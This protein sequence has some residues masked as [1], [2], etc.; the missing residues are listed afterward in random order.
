MHSVILS[1]RDTK[2]PVSYSTE[3][4]RDKRKTVF[5]CR[6]ISFISASSFTVYST[7]FFGGGG[8]L[9]CLLVRPPSNWGEGGAA[10]QEEE[11]ED[12]VISRP[13]FPL[14]LLLLL[15]F[16]CPGPCAAGK[17]SAGAGKEKKG[18]YP[19]LRPRARVVFPPPRLK[20]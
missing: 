10:E 7:L 13:V 1:P 2:N 18:N 15:L 20:N 8:P 5:L 14:L 19:P 3:S 4:L 11:E 12:K 6:A 17:I 9:R 16:P